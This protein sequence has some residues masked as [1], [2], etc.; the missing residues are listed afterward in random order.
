MRQNQGTTVYKLY[1]LSRE[2]CDAV[3]AALQAVGADNLAN[4]IS[5][6]GGR[7]G[8]GKKQF[9]YD[10]VSLCNTYELGSREAVCTILRLLRFSAAPHVDA[11]D[12]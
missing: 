8:C 4:A 11:E 7:W 1:A 3:V 2:D 6:N 12:C 9:I 10:F 5:Y